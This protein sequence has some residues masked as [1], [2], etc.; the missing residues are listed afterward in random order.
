VAQA[1]KQY[2]YTRRL[3]A[4][5]EALPA[6]KSPPDWDSVGSRRQGSKA[7]SASTA[8]PAAFSWGW[9]ALARRHQAHPIL[10]RPEDPSPNSP[11]RRCGHRS[12][13][14]ANRGVSDAPSQPHG[15]GWLT[16]SQMA[17]RDVDASGPRARLSTSS[18]AR[19]YSC[20]HVATRFGRVTGRRP[21]PTIADFPAAN[22]IDRAVA[23]QAYWRYG[24]FL[25]RRV[26]NKEG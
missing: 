17:T 19:L 18:T 26:Q 7:E 16:S 12:G 9:D 15:N 2:P 24:D 25:T 14:S 1:F 8:Q 21:H 10:A 13:A 4:R 22:D 5:A 11:R 6:S 20:R 3:H 23:R